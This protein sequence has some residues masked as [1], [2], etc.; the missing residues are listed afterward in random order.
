MNDTMKHTTIEADSTV[1]IIRITRDFMA[2]P[3]QV[4]R[5]HTD[6]DLFVRWVGPDEMATTVDYWDARTGGSWRYVALREGTELGFHGCFHE[7]R[8]DRI[9]QTFTWEGDP[10]GVALQT[11]DFDDLGGGRT[12]LR[13]QSL[14]C[15]FES[16]DAWLRSGMKVGLDHGFAALDS[17][18]TANTIAEGAEA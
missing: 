18:L 6:P 4:L 7:V 2:K 14:C 12:R 3:S 10:D 1:P 13:I 8:P 15:S 17:L 11:L 16:R 5:A 9:V